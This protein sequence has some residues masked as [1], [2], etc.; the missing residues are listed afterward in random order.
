MPGAGFCESAS[1]IS[2]HYLVLQNFIKKD[3]KLLSNE[4][5]SGHFEKVQ[6]S[7]PHKD[8]KILQIS[9]LPACL[10]LEKKQSN[11]NGLFTFSLYCLKNF[12]S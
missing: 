4:E 12:C 10:L 3:A 11:D 9:M 2:K 6:V 1:K 5:E 7:L 8:R